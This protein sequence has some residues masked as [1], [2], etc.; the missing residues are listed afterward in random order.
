MTVE[1]LRTE[2][3]ARNLNNR[4]LKSQLA[5]RLAK[6]LKIEAEKTDSECR[7][8]DSQAETE[9]DTEEKKEVS[10]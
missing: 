9:T 5:A 1:T 7:D 6:A 10:F 2:L 3:K 4:G 8:K